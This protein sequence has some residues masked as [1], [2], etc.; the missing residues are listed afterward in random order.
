MDVLDTNTQKLLEQISKI[1]SFD[2]FYLAG[3]TALAL[4]L[5]HRK[6]IDLNFFS[7]KDFKSN[8]VNTLNLNYEVVTLFDNSIE[9]IIDGVKILFF[10][11]GFPLKK[12]K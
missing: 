4:Q 9:L 7:P 5:K 11:F 1:S 2:D 3:G 6:S 8:I 12:K 10:Y